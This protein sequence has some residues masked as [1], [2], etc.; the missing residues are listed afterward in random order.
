MSINVKIQI[1]SAITL[2]LSALQ[3]AQAQEQ[4]E[5]PTYDFEKC[6]GVS[7][8]GQNDC[9]TASGACGKTQEKDRDPAYWVYVPAGTCVKLAGG[10]LEAK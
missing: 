2:A 8:A 10:S 5:K 6:Y 4:V 9:F 3:H 1:A 7:A